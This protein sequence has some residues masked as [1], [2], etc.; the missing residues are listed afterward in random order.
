MQRKAWFFSIPVQIL[1]MTRGSCWTSRLDQRFNNFNGGIMKS[2]INLLVLIGFATLLTT[3]DAHSEITTPNL[4][5]FGSSDFQTFGSSIDDNLYPNHFTVSD[6]IEKTDEFSDSADNS[7]DAEVSSFQ[8]P[9]ELLLPTYSH[10]VAAAI[11]LT[12]WINHRTPV[13]VP[14]NRY[15]RKG[16]FGTWTPDPNSCLNVRG[17]ILQ[18]MS[19]VPITTKPNAE[20]CIVATGQW[21]DPYSGKVFKRPYPDVEIDHVVPLKNAY[22]MGAAKWSNK[23]RC[24]FSNFTKNNYHLIPVSAHENEVKSD[25]TPYDYMPSAESFHC[26]YVR[27]WLKIKLLWNLAMVPPE[28]EAIHQVIAKNHCP[29]SQLRMSKAEL[30]KGRADIEA[31]SVMCESP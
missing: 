9:N 31:G 22:V 18:R 19:E 20:G 1:K 13:V 16:Q 29:P 24:W 5:T 3:T 6:Q 11:S 4:Q 30:L 2:K 12:N 17:L 27:N 23:K 28:A 14:R 7:S 10:F 26:A 15:D 8:N 21:T 25:S